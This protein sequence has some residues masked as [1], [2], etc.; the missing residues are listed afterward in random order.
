MEEKL[1]AEVLSTET[2]R[3]LTAGDKVL[4]YFRD[5]SNTPEE[6]EEFDS[7]LA[8]LAAWMGSSHF[9]V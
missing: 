8:G 5:E 1:L 3:R 6:F 4:D 9:K 2:Q 7:L